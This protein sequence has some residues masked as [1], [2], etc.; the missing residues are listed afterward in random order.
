[1]L[2]DFLESRGKIELP[3]SPPAAGR[4]SCGGAMS[5][6]A[7]W[8]EHCIECGAPHC[9]ATCDKFSKTTGGKC[10]RFKDGIQKVRFADGS[11][12]FAVTFLPWGKLQL[13]Y[14]G[15]ICSRRFQGVLVGLDGFLAPFL[16]FLNCLLPF[17]P[18][19]RNPVAIYQTLRAY[20][21]RHCVRRKSA[22]DCLSAVCYVEKP[23]HLR[24]SVVMADGSEVFTNEMTM[25][26]GW[27]HFAFELPA[28]RG[29]FRARVF[30]IEGTT[31][32]VCFSSLELSAANPAAASAEFVKCVAW[33]L[34]NTVWN[35]ILSEDGEA[36][37]KLR[38]E[39][40]GVI[41]ELDRRGI[42]NT[43]CSKNDYDAAWSVLR[44]MGIAEY[45]V[46]PEI[47][48]DP[49]SENIK[50]IAGNMNIGLDAFA[51]V[52]DSENERGEI[53]AR[54]PSVRVFDERN[55]GRLLK[56]AC[57]NPPLSEE[58]ALRRQSY[59]A[60]MG[61][62]KTERSF[63]GSREDFLRSCEIALTCERVKS[64][65]DL[66]RCWE[67]VNRTNQLTLAAHRYREPE[68]N[69]LTDAPGIE[70]YSICCRDKYGDYGI[71]GFIAL[72]IEKEVVSVV[73]FVMSCR[74][75]KKYCE[76]SVLL[77]LADLMY[78]RG[79]RKMVTMVVPTGR[80]GALVEA[81]D[82]MP[83]IKSEMTENGQ[84]RFQYEL[85]LFNG[86]SAW[87]EKYRNPVSEVQ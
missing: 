75:A 69:A 51:F 79:V 21:L 72:R 87:A 53:S 60:E 40:V 82:A 36:G 28:L 35:G 70:A 6:A 18:W 1:M 26:A 16:R 32:P 15:K 13:T 3:V 37:V 9:Y 31:V 58:S 85:E 48:W 17:L 8:E 24:C 30:S 83:F 71:V 43:V 45:F 54:I 20:L 84:I 2:V 33:D 7:Y 39:V 41:R 42:M 10:R 52:D 77:F 81:F 27:N 12:G 78:A 14:Y 5:A 44:R 38:K 34:D 67:L 11:N 57:F 86:T 76:Q 47:N 23:V 74:V 4:P 63:S 19:N 56:L 25:T 50:A 61:R 22:V 80:N 46:F 65:P 64:G 29:M 73:E 59:I 49:K 55:I 62:R 66:L 68:F